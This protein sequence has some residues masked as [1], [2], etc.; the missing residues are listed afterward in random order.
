MFWLIRTILRLAGLAVLLLAAGF[1]YLNLR[2]D[3][4]NACTALAQAYGE[5]MPRALDKLADKYPLQVGLLNTVLKGIQG[6]QAK[7]QEMTR[8]MVR[9]DMERDGEQP[10]ALTCTIEL[11]T[12][13]LDRD[14][15]RDHMAED[16]ERSLGL[17]Q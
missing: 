13:D 14:A 2:Y 8:D 9:R 12:A 1:V 4:G 6:S 5:E 15:L 17:A 16:L 3:T 10:S 7:I 11:V